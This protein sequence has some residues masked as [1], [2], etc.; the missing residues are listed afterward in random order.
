MRPEGRFPCSQPTTHHVPVPN[1]NPT[2]PHSGQKD[3][4]RTKDPTQSHSGQ[5]NRLSGQWVRWGRG[6]GFTKQYVFQ[7]PLCTHDISTGHTKRPLH[8]GQ[9]AS[10]QQL[11]VFFRTD[12]GGIVQFHEQPASV[13]L[14]TRGAAASIIL[15]FKGFFSFFYVILFTLLMVQQETVGPP[16]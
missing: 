5:K 7:L 15:Q 2:R 3:N 4:Y 14:V 1:C 13:I 10:E 12:H 8:R 16:L 9:L 6:L 11:A